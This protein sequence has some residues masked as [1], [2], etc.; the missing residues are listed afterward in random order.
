MIP[1]S[2]CGGIWNRS[3]CLNAPTGAWCSLTLHDL[4][5]TRKH[6]SQCIY[7]CVVLPDLCLRGPTLIATQRLNAPTGAWCSL[8]REGEHLYALVM[9]LNAPT[10]AW[11]SLTHRRQAWRRTLQA[12]QCTY[13]CVVLP[14]TTANTVASPSLQVSM[15]L[16]VRGAPWKVILGVSQVISGGRY[17]DGPPPWGIMGVKDISP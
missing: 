17:G 10:G 6:T 9:C 11:C 2:R 13:R 7:R 16:Q 15:H 5:G 12:S 8:T 4:T 1:D 14:D 3:W